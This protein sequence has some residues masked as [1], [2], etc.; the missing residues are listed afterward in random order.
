MSRLVLH[1]LGYCCGAVLDLCQTLLDLLELLVQL[2]LVQ[3]E[4]LLR[5]PLQLGTDNFLL[6]LV[7]MWRH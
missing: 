5:G 4:L 3:L 6:S 1:I 2:L 7:Q